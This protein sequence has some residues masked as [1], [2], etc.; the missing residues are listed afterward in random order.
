MH[1]N[2]KLQ[3]FHPILSKNIRKRNYDIQYG[4]PIYIYISTPLPLHHY[5][6]VNTQIFVSE[7]LENLEKNLSLTRPRTN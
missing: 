3:I 2:F 7:F 4:K 5:A 6:R 1:I